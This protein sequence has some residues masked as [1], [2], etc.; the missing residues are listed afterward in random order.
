WKSCFSSNFPDVSSIHSSM[1][2]K[3]LFGSHPVAECVFPW[4]NDEILVDVGIHPGSDP[5]KEDGKSTA[6][7]IPAG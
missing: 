1:N 7:C 4:G 3:H 5:K 2:P 6:R